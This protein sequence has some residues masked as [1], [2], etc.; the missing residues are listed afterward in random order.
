[1]VVDYVEEFFLVRQIISQFAAGRQV[2]MSHSLN[3]T[4]KLA[5]FYYK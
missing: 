5:V 2:C 1:M 4:L 3:R